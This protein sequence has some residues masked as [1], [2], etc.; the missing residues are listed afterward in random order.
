MFSKHYEGKLEE[1]PPLWN[2]TPY[3]GMAKSKEAETTDEYRWLAVVDVFNQW[4]NRT[5]RR[6]YRDAIK[7][8]PLHTRGFTK[9]AGIESMI[10][11]LKTA[12]NKAFI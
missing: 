5:W 4:Y 2:C 11:I 7:N 9:G 10:N 8:S 12:T 6:N 3:T 1:H